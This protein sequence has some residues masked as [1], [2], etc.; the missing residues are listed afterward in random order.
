MNI[1]L[2]IILA[3][4]L[5]WAVWAG[6][7][8]GIVVQLGGIAGL[9]AGVWLAVRYGSAVGA[10]FGIDPAADP[11]IGFIVILVVVVLFIGVMGR[12]LKGVFRFAGLAA[13]DRFG[14]AALSLVK[15][16][17]ILGLLLYAFGQLN[18]TQHWVEQ[19]RLEDS[20]LY[21][22]LVAVAKFTFPYVAMLKNTLVCFPHPPDDCHSERAISSEQ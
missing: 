15:A 14:G 5:V 6:F 12:L 7:R 3:V 1:F 19:E 21:I 13:L 20:R 17:L 2:D 8:N 10:W 18:R 11:I 4:P 9:F 16:A 22:P